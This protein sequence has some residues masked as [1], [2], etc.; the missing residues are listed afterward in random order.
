MEC[1]FKIQEPIAKPSKKAQ[2]PSLNSPEREL[3]VLVAGK[4]SAESAAQ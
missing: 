1:K 3:G 2:G 4:M